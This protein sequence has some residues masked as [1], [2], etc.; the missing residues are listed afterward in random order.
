MKEQDNSMQILNRKKEARNISKT[1]FSYQIM[2]TITPNI[3][4]D[5][6]MNKADE[7]SIKKIKEI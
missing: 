1:I 4:L 5:T 7:E 3:S 2:Y 6:L